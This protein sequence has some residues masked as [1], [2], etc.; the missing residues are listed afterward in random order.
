[1]YKKIGFAVLSSLIIALNFQQASA[2][3]PLLE[4]PE[5]PIGKSYEVINSSINVYSSPNEDARILFKL[6]KDM[7]IFPSEFKQV[8]GE[9]WFRFEPGN[10]WVMGRDKDDNSLLQEVDL[11]ENHIEDYYGILNEPHRFALKMVKYPG[12]TARLETYE[13]VGNDYIFKDSYEASYPKEGSKDTFGDLKTVGGRG[14]RYIYRTRRTGMGG[15]NLDGETF[16]AYKIAF[17]MPHD[18]YEK[19]LKG[20]LNSYQVAKLPAINKNHR[21]EFYPH[22]H[23]NLGADIVLHTASKGSRGCVIVE[24]EMMSHI[25]QNDLTSKHDTEL[26]PF[27]IYDEDVIAPPLGQLL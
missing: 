24:N 14:I 26:I 6:Y 19:Y 7:D 15:R 13:K 10:N 22:P 16:G 17:P 5:S 4:A 20:E 1:M 11:N 2:E 18:G 3:L 27:V 8:D 23:S 9:F 12:A 21:G 25:Y